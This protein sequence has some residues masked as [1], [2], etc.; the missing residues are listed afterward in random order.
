MTKSN[1]Y[2][3]LMVARKE[4]YDIRMFLTPVSA[5]LKSKFVVHLHLFVSPKLLVSLFDLKKAATMVCRT[6]D[7]SYINLSLHF[8]I[9]I[10]PVDIRVLE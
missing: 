9:L 5:C 4:L 10:A 8:L 7:S 3:G 1:I 2:V 6:F